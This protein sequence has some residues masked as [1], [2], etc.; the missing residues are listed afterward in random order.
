[1]YFATVAAL[2][3]PQTNSQKYPEFWIISNPRTALIDALNAL[4][5]MQKISSL[6]LPI[7]KII[8]NNL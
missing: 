4:Y 3:T 7:L 1:M 5:A 2:K 6:Q 8:K